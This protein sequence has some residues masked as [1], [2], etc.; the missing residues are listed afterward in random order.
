MRIAVLADIHGNIDALEAVLEDIQKQQVDQIVIAG[1]VVIGLPH[2]LECWQR[3]ESLK[4]PIIRGNHE[5][6][7]F[8]LDTPDAPESWKTERYA[9][10][11]QAY[12]QFSKGT[13]EEMRQLPL[14]YQSSDFLIV[15]ASYRNDVDAVTAKSTESELQEMFAGSSQPYIIRAHNHVWFN[16]AWQER[17]L[18]SIGSVGL[19]LNGDKTAQYGIAEKNNGQWTLERRDVSYDIEKAI[20]SFETTNYFDSAGSVGKLFRQ[21]L[22]TAR[23]ELTPFWKA[24]SSIVDKGELTLEQAMNR[25]LE[26]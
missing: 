11:H 19:P 18:Y 1:D 6:Y 8:A 16:C 20:R 26:G 24:Y 9:P 10:V 15:H 25:Y 13:I 17:K 21:E 22:I 23:H 7:L 3:L 5:R 14:H 12:Q 4:C 2:S